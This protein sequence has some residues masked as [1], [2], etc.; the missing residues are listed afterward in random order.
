MARAR[1]STLLILFAQ[2]NIIK[3]H[4]RLKTHAIQSFKYASLTP[5][6]LFVFCVVAIVIAPAFRWIAVNPRPVAYTQS[7]HAS[8]TPFSMI[9][10]CD[11][12]YTQHFIAAL[13][14]KQL[15]P[16][17]KQPYSSHSTEVV[18][19]T[20]IDL[21][22]QRVH[23]VPYQSGVAYSLQSLQSSGCDRTSSLSNK[24]S[25]TPLFCQLAWRH[26]A[27]L[28]HN[29]LPPENMCTSNCQLSY[30]NTHVMQQQ[31]FSHE[32]LCIQLPKRI[33]MKA[34]QNL[35]VYLNAPIVT[36]WLFT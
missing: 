31:P 12:N 24:T 7:T 27:V 32:Q 15:W 29:C 10:T 1:Q 4:T 30:A 35:R 33:C 23:S 21:A 11:V 26:S 8:I 3:F 25:P 14:E 20:T 22:R 9:R 17:G 36:W 19:M 5:V 18:S 2:I 13:R 28:W 6:L 16:M 34:K